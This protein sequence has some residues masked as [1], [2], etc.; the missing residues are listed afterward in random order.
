MRAPGRTDHHT[1]VFSVAA[2]ATNKI[3]NYTTL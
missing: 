2:T 1:M 3:G